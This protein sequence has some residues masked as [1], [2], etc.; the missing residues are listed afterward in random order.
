MRTV[1]CVG[2]AAAFAI[3]CV[4]LSSTVVWAERLPLRQYVSADGLPHERVKRIVADSRGFI[5]FATPDGLGRFDG[6]R[7]VTWRR[8]DGLP[9]DS[10]NDILET[11]NGVYWFATNGG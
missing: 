7:F 11:R 4:V 2:R 10:I 6:N 8:T 9:H 5:W 3:A 1:T